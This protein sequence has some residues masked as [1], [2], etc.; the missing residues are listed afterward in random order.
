M[1]HVQ[2]LSGGKDSTALAFAL[3]EREPRKYIRVC[4]P[5][6]DELPDMVAHWR[7]LEASLGPITY[8]RAAK[9]L[10]G[11]I[12][13]WNALPNN[14]Q[15]WC[16]RMLK[17]QPYREWL[18]R[19]STYGDVVSYVG[20]RADEEERVGGIYDDIAGVEQRYPLREWGW[21]EGDVLSYLEQLGVVIPDRTDCARCYHQT[22]GE[23]WHLSR[24]YPDIYADAERQEAETGHTFRNPKRDTWPTALSDLRA[25]FEAGYVPPRT[26]QQID[27]FRG[28]TKCRVC[29]I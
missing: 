11:L 17:I 20:L 21:T 25:K 7:R 4:T 18:T 13:H 23:W 9:D 12:E 5:T 28:S 29:S 22:L 16:T 3:A 26:V 27:L 15:R 19:V 8:V 10:T 14:L 6:G 2:A 1:I 24:R